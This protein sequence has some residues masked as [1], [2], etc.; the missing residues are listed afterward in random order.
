LLAA[1]NREHVPRAA[2]T[3]S[4]NRELPAAGD[5]SVCA[6]ACDWREGE[7][8]EQRRR[9]SSK[10]SGITKLST[11]MVDNTASSI[12]L[13]YRRILCD[14][15]STNHENREEF[16]HV[17]SLNLQKKIYGT[18]KLRAR[19]CYVLDI[20]QRFKIFIWLMFGLF[21]P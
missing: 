9:E 16:K 19:P 2:T 17:I 3:C 20:C 10:N 15:M 14:T 4:S 7:G 8:R 1:C 13:L 18:L 6:G 21:H 11:G 5:S 12:S